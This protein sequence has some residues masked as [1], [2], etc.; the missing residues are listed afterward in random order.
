MIT[1]RGSRWRV[2][3]QAG[4]DP[5]TQRRLQLSGSAATKPEA[6]KLER[7]LMRRAVESATPDLTIR[8]L[9]KEFWA[10]DPRLAAT[11]RAN[12]R[13]NLDS[14]VLPIIGD[15]RCSEIR[16]RLVASFLR[17]LDTDR[18]LSPGTIRKI[19]TV[20]SSVMSFAVAMEYVESNAVVKV[21]PPQLPESRRV[22]PTLEET[23]AILLAAE[24]HDPEF[25]T[26]LWVAAEEGG[27]RGET[28]AL[29]WGGVDFE[30]GELVIDSTV[31]RGDDGV[32]VRPRTK[33]R[34]PRRVA[35]SALT[36]G[37]LRERR[38]APRPDPRAAGGAL[39]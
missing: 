5:I 7:E 36:L 34:Q 17:Y 19:R 39:G 9:V 10:S 25:L 2:V 22:A 27:R 16:P 21:P 37:R 23:A 1:K 31:T 33:N 18:N 4:R 8:Q 12:Y 35:V 20:L 13:A 32:H 14:H 6:L 30:R 28:L 3:V 38:S 15:R 29:R 11:T 24:V 26:Y